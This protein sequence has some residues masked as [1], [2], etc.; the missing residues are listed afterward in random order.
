LCSNVDSL[1][2]CAKSEIIRSKNVQ[3]VEKNAQKM[4]IGVDNRFEKRYNKNIIMIDNGGRD[5]FKA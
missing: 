2:K 1:K 3:K 5:V 4:C